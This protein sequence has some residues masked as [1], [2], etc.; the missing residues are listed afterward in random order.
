MS[1]WGSL[2]GVRLPCGVP[3]PETT[4]PQSYRTALFVF[5]AL[6]GPSGTWPSDDVGRY[7]HYRG[8]GK[9]S[10]VEDPPRRGL[11]GHSASR[12]RAC[13]LAEEFP[14]SDVMAAWAKHA[15]A[16]AAIAWRTRGVSGQPAVRL[17]RQ[18]ANVR[19]CCRNVELRGAACCLRGGQGLPCQPA[20]RDI[21]ASPREGVG[22]PRDRRLLGPRWITSDGVSGQV[23]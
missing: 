20:L 1:P 2:V 10:A 3:P 14:V 12:E 9:T 16:I 17:A 11:S 4:A 5:L 8:L 21:V 15:D 6:L 13:L 22:G 19:V 7:S 23:L 18:P